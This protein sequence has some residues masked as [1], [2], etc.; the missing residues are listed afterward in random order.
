MDLGVDVLAT[1]D[2]KD[3]GYPEPVTLSSYVLANLVAR[4]HATPAL[5]LVARLENAL[6]EQY[7]LADNFNTPGRGLYVSVSYSMGA[8][9]QPARVAENRAG[10]SPNSRGAYSAPAGPT[11]V[12]R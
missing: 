12:G 7:E 1:G 9:T 2:R 10:D 3:F 8:G 5:T 6:N 4:W 11:R